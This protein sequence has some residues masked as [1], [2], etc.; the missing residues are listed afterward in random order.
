M[1]KSR[2]VPL[3]MKVKTRQSTWSIAEYEQTKIRTDHNHGNHNQSLIIIDQDGS[4]YW[5]NNTD[6]LASLPLHRSICFLV[7]IT[8]LW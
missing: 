5:R 6:S 7:S 4:F 8:V 1:L 3:G 2:G